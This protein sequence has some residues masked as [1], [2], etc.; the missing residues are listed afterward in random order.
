MSS[1][2]LNI[3]ASG[4]RAYRASL[5]V[6]GDNIANAQ[7]AGY[8][9]RSLRLSEVSITSLP[10]FRYRNRTR[11]DGVDIS[12]TVRATDEWRTGDARLAAS[13][14]GRAQASATWMVNTETALADGE[15]G[16]GA[17]LANMFA[18]GDALAADPLS[19]A[20][21]SAFLASI[22]DAAASIRGNATELSRVSAGVAD[23][24]KASVDGLNANLAALAD[25]NLAI[26]RTSAGSTANA[27]LADQRDTLIDK[28]AGQTDVSVAIAEDGS[29]TLTRAGATLVAGGDSATLALTVATDG[30]LSFTQTFNAVTSGFSP[31]GG[32]LGG[33]TVSAN[34]VA[35][36]RAAL[37]T[38]ASDLATALNNWHAGGRTPGNANGPP[39]LDASGGAIALTALITDPSQVAAADTGGTANGNMLALSTVRSASGVEGQW[40]ALVANQAQTTASAR[41]DETRTSARKD[42]ADAARDVVEGVDLDREAADLLRYQQA[43][44]A[45][46]RVIQMAKETIDT[47]LG[48][49]R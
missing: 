3:G 44:E 46:A 9:R 20:P 29:A 32:A 30:R 38:L 35:D 15:T 40:A 41:A 19:R 8:A 14:H 43:Y 42:T 48:L 10:D 16:T 24:A 39:L 28:I 47:I 22:D 25:L 13:S 31:S 21:R 2:L 33:L 27:E 37:D 17:S 7:T 12:A 26:R 11:F 4:L 18:K 6:T 36:L 45:S 5:A 34:T 1:D 23:A 49:F